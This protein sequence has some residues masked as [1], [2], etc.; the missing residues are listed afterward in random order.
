MIMTNHTKRFKEEYVLEVLPKILITT[1]FLLMEEKRHPSIRFI[2]LLSH[3]H[4][5]FLLFVEAY[6]KL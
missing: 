2:R 4:C 3:I 1:I 6:P 5:L